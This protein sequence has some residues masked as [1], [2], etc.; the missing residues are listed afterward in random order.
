M[1]KTLQTLSLPLL[2]GALLAAAPKTTPTPTKTPAPLQVQKVPFK[3]KP[4]FW[5]PK[6][7]LMKFSCGDLKL[8]AFSTH[9]KTVEF[10]LTEEIFNEADCKKSVKEL[11][12]TGC[13]CDDAD[14]KCLKTEEVEPKAIVCNNS[15]CLKLEGESYGKLQVVNLGN[16]ITRQ[17]CEKEL[18][19]R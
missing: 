18:K 12:T 3:K 5:S 13:F 1:N 14:L 16:F 8:R 15:F 10:I 19:T 6:A 17:A 9:D 11:Q 4:A 7:D 2:L